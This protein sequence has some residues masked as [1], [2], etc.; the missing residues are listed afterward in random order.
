M[1]TA[2]ASWNE[3]PKPR[4]PTRATRPP[5]RELWW[6]ENEL[7]H[8]AFQ[9]RKKEKL[10]YILRHI[11]ADDIRHSSVIGLRQNSF[12]QLV[13]HKCSS[14]NT[15][16]TNHSVTSTWQKNCTRLQSE[17]KDIKIKVWCRH[18]WLLF[19][20][21]VRSKHWWSKKA[22]WNQ[23]IRR[24]YE[25]IIQWP[26]LMQHITTT[27]LASSTACS[28]LHCWI[29]MGIIVTELSWIIQLIVQTSETSYFI[30]VS[31]VLCFGFLPVVL[32][33]CPRLNGLHL[34]PI[35]CTVYKPQLV[36]SSCVLSPCSLW[37][38]CGQ[39]FSLHL[40]QR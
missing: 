37:I 2:H 39:F 20:H 24:N 21:R 18:L 36:Q 31:R 22:E 30:V 8:R 34:R 23:K 1:Q 35:F 12:L 17:A 5:E 27:Q 13:N 29:S 15:L 28:E 19:W 3:W 25:G 16:L 6:G 11:N 4:S 10:K 38:V 14:I 9:V 26:T 40:D 33:T 7:E 32:I